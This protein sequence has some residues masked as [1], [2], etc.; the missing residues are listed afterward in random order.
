ESNLDDFEAN[1][2]STP[3]TDESSEDPVD[4]NIDP[5]S[6][7]PLQYRPQ[8]L[9]KASKKKKQRLELPGENKANDTKGKRSGGS[10]FDDSPVLGPPDPFANF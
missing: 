7:M 10:I 1:S 9:I 6:G 2:I 4:P 3:Y 5:T 8:K